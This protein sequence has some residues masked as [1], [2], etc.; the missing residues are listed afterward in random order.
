ME[1]ADN[2]RRNPYLGSNIKGK[3][4]AFPYVNDRI[5]DI[6]GTNGVLNFEDMTG[7]LSMP[8]NQEMED[9]EKFIFRSTWEKKDFKD[10]IYLSRTLD[11]VKVGLSKAI[12]KKKKKFGG[13]R[14]VSEV[15]KKLRNLLVH[16]LNASW[17]LD[18]DNVMS[19]VSDYIEEWR[20]A[21]VGDIYKAVEN[22]T[23]EVVHKSKWQ[24][25]DEGVFKINIDAL[26]N[27]LSHSIR[28]GVII[29]DRSSI[30]KISAA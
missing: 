11:V 28:L 8:I 2:N 27:S 19:W 6:V 12:G 22:N 17:N 26:I 29:R 14:E 15:I 1:V 16:K 24:P 21:Q 30:V 10:G 25:P 13:S 9:M 3:E 5:A 23:D 4:I 18:S 7:D 20:E